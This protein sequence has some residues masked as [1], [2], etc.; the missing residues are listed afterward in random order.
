MQHRYI[1]GIVHY[2]RLETPTN[3]NKVKSGTYLIIDECVKMYQVGGGLADVQRPIRDSDEVILKVYNCEKEYA[4][5]KLPLSSTVSVI[6][7]ILH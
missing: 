7:Y 6:G 1:D 2:Y 4:T 3:N 5:L